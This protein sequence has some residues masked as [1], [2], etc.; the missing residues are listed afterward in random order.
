LA[1]ALLAAF[2]AAA[3]LAGQGAAGAEAPAGAPYPPSL[4]IVGLDW[5]PA[6]SIVRRAGGSDN[7]PITWAD[8][9][10]LYTAYG[11]GHGFEPKVRE[12]LSLG[13]AR[14]EG[15]AGSFKGENVRSPSGE[16][17]GGGAAGRKASGML[18]VG[19]TLYM[20]ARNADRKGKGSQL[21]WSADHGRRWTWGS[22]RFAEL[23]Y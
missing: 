10:R 22:W 18:M 9:G 1:H 12:K 6:K 14:V 19:G 3:L 4:V 16:Q 5:A 13:L 15:G 20:W 8:D 17:K 23:G 7:W 21:A 11:D 2:A